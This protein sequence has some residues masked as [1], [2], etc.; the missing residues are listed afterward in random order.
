VFDGKIYHGRTG[1]AGEGG[2][3]TIDYRGPRCGCGKRGCVEALCSGP[4]IALRA[5]ARIGDSHVPSRML[6]LAN[7][8]AEQVKAEHVG[9]AY[10]EGDALAIEVLE[11]TADLLAIWFGNTVDLLE[12]D[13]IVVGGGV[14]DL[15]SPFFDRI[16]KVTTEWSINPRSSEIPL[17]MARYGADAGIAGAASLCR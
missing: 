13:V 10:A 4:A 1:S 7:G 8:F 6:E 12:P 3:N 15:M 11:E 2:H 17:V 14:A 9:K 16:R 5:R